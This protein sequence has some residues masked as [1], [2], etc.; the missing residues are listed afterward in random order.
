MDN[1]YFEVR[2]LTIDDLELAPLCFQNER[3]GNAVVG[4]AAQYAQFWAEGIKNPVYYFRNVE[5]DKQRWAGISEFG[6]HPLAPQHGLHGEDLAQADAPTIQYHK[7]GEAPKS[8]EIESTQ[9]YSLL[10]FTDDGNG[11]VKAEF[12][13]GKNGCILD[14]EVTPFPVAVFSHANPSQ[15]APYFQ[16]NTMVKGTYMG[17]PVMGMGGFDRTYI[18]NRVA[19]NEGEKEKNY[20]A[21][22][23]CICALY[24]GIREDGRKECVYALIT[25][26]NGKGI[27]MYYIDGEEP[28][29][30]D[31]VHLSAKFCHLPYVDDDTVVYTNAVWQIG[32]KTIHFDG[33]WGTKSFTAY[34]K[35]EKHG[36]SQCFGNWYE[37][38]VPYKH[39][40]E[41]TFNENSG[42]AY[43]DRIREMGFVVE[44]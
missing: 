30:T 40:L 37:G 41:H 24:S 18:V 11:G 12:K 43:S 32:S 17:K 16:V 22:Y 1:S 25:D 3:D 44:D 39:T 34:P 23:R 14:L 20:A 4:K 42:D 2:K 33:K 6:E 31:Q 29:V 9:P 7:T 28:V 38:D 35:V 19:D 15:P 21:T 26:E 10:R 36:Q 27:G 13:E 5:P 8:F